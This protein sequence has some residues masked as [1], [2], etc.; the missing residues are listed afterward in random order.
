MDIGNST[1]FYQFLARTSLA[2]RIPSGNKLMS[3]MD[4][5]QYNCNCSEQANRQSIMNRCNAIYEEIVS[6]LNHV[7]ITLIFQNV[8]DMSVSFS[9]DGRHLRTIMR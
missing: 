9:R 8:P 4:E 6:G 5:Y 3:C 1:Q 7:T 2:S